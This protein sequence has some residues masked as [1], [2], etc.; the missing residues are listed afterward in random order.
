MQWK[1]YRSH[2]LA[3]TDY[4]LALP[5]LPPYPGEAW[6]YFAE[7]PYRSAGGRADAHKLQR[8]QSRISGRLHESL[9]PGDHYGILRDAGLRQLAESL[10]SLFTRAASPDASPV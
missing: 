3:L 1:L 6:L 7:S 5:D 8:W 2:R 10:Q 4:W 9:L